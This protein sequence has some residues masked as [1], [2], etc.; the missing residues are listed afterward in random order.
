MK[1]FLGATFLAGT[2][3]FNTT[4]ATAAPAHTKDRETIYPNLGENS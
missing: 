2:L 1:K 4:S 3:L